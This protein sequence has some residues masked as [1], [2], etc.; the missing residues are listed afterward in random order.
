MKR[1]LP[2]TLILLPLTAAAGGHYGK[3][4]EIKQPQINNYSPKASAN[5]AANSFAKGG[6]SSANSTATGGNSLANGFGGSATSSSGGNSLS[7]NT[8]Q[9]WPSSFVSGF[10]ASSPAGCRTGLGVQGGYG[11]IVL[12]IDDEDCELVVAAQMELQRGNIWSYC[13]LMEKT[14]A[15]EIAEISFSDCRAN[16]E[17]TNQYV[18]NWLEEFNRK[19]PPLD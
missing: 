2:I 9:Q 6:N 11:G 19:Y 16:H 18:S 14:E 17:P 5:S 10:S 13:K 8:A 1:T 3:S 7:V 12:P 15:Y 4:T